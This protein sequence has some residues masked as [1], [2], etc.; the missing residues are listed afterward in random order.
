[1]LNFVRFLRVLIIIFISVF[2]A[3]QIAPA[4]ACTADEITLSNG[5]CKPVQFTMTVTSTDP[6][7][8]FDFSFYFNAKGTLYID[9]GDNSTVQTVSKDKTNQPTR[10]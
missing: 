7:D 3:F 8:G 5:T 6:T 10:V 9:W 4:V 2:G 1:M